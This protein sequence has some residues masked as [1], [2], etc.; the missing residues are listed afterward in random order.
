MLIRALQDSD[1]RTKNDPTFT[2]VTGRSYEVP[3]AV[4]KALIAD[5]KAERTY[6]RGT[7]F[8]CTDCKA[9]GKNL[10]PGPNG[11]HDTCE[12]CHGAGRYERAN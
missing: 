10:T 1:E 4:A 6:E 12:S 8:V 3:L 2:L 5:G 7:V 9:T 11:K